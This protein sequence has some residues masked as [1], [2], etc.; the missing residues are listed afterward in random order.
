MSKPRLVITAVVLEGRKQA[1]VAQAHNVSPGWVSKLVARHRLEGEAAFEP[2]SRKP[3]STRRAVL[4][5]AMSLIAT[6]Q[7]LRRGHYEIA[8]GES[9][10]DRL[11]VAF[12]GLALCA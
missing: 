1:E 7:N 12:D 4:R 11:R 3:H 6:P 2:R 10:H 8:T 5:W 9:A